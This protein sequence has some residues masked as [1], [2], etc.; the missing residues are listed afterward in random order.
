MTTRFK[1]LC[2]EYYY[3]EGLQNFLHL[4]SNKNTEQKRICICLTDTVNKNLYSNIDL[5]TSF[6]L[7]VGN[8]NDN[9]RLIIC[10]QDG[11]PIFDI[12]KNSIVECACMNLCGYKEFILLLNNNLEYKIVI[13]T[14]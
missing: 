3:Q 8:T 4:F 10:K 12:Y 2:N 13:Y 5:T 9:T 14:K 7:S 1:R 11:T 6:V